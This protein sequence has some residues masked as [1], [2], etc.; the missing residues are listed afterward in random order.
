[1]NNYYNKNLKK[2]AQELRTETVSKAEKYIWKAGLSRNQMGVKFKRQR[3]ILNFIVDFFCAE[4]KL[5]I[6]IDGNSH[7]NKGEY[8]RYRQDKLEHFG[9]TVIR[10]NEGDVLNNFDEVNNT[11]RHVIEVL[12]QK[13]QLP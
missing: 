7:T 5:I 1:M 10:F 2:Y 6:E 13:N 11:I 9:F 8:D 4:L 12:K 3:P